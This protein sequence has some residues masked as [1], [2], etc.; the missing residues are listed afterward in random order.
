MWLNEVTVLVLFVTFL[1]LTCAGYAR[2]DNI[3]DTNNRSARVYLANDARNGQFKS[4]AQLS[5]YAPSAHTSD[6]EIS[7]CGRSLIDSL[8]ILTAAHCVQRNPKPFQ[9]EVI[10]GFYNSADTLSQRKY[11]VQYYYVHEAYKPQSIQDQTPPV[12]DIA[13]CVLNE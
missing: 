13:I 10:L 11:L 3:T 8:H 2:L 12:N 7:N 5:M 4:F 1:N 9:I 6:I